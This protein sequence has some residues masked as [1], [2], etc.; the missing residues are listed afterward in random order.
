[1]DFKAHK[2]LVTGGKG[3]FY[4]VSISFW[5]VNSMSH[6]GGV[7]LLCV[8]MYVSVFCTWTGGCD[9]ALGCAEI[10]CHPIQPSPA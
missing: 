8:P 4:P 9:S 5:A 2:E 10:W 7:L 6:V 1:M 3:L